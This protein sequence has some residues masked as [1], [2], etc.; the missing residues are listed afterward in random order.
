MQV[1]SF[2]YFNWKKYEGDRKNEHSHVYQILGTI[3]N[4]KRLC[5]VSCKDIESSSVSVWNGL[6][7]SVSAYC[8][9]SNS[10]QTKGVIWCMEMV[11]NVMS[12]RV[13]RLPSIIN[14]LS[15]SGYLEAASVMA[16]Q[17]TDKESVKIKLELSSVACFFHYPAPFSCS[18]WPSLSAPSVNLN[19]CTWPFHIAKF[20]C[21]E[22]LEWMTF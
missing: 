1:Y 19:P 2:T 3:K 14:L 5:W 15:M 4:W 8:R 7:S 21:L 18:F 6:V 13:T 20:T 16:A 17:R 9:N 12:I 10:G 22:E 11:T